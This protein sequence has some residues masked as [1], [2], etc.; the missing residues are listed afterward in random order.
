[1]E[2]LLV[3]ILNRTN[4][5][6]RDFAYWLQGFFEINNPKTLNE[7]QTQCIKQQLDLVF[8]NVTKKGLKK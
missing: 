1:M 3:G 2:L 5:T 4:M 6:E 8:K 7:E